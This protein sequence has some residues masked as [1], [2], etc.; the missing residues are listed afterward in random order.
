[1]W[2]EGCLPRLDG[3]GSLIGF[4]RLRPG[5]NDQRNFTHMIRGM[6]GEET[7]LRP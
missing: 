3:V 7:Q 2:P 6:L 1:M 5:F 4:Q